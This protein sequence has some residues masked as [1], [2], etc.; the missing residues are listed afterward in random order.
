M[1]FISFKNETKFL[2]DQVHQLKNEYSNSYQIFLKREIQLSKLINQFQSDSYQFN[3]VSNK[4]ILKFD[5]E[6][7]KDFTLI[8]VNYDQRQ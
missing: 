8:K 3:F 1:V 4:K 6:G 7:L 5:R 2:K